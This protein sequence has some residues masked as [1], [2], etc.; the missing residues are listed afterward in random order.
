MKD[1]AITVRRTTLVAQRVNNGD[2]LVDVGLPAT[3]ALE[4]KKALE[5]KPAKGFAVITAKYY[6]ALG[7]RF[8]VNNPSVVVEGK[9]KPSPELIAGIRAFQR[10]TELQVTGALNKAT[11]L[12][13]AAVEQG[14]HFA[15]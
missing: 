11:L 3:A 13:A 10:D 4:Y 2:F 6:S 7:K 5:S 14:A 15:H 8:N 1:A 12:D 9:K